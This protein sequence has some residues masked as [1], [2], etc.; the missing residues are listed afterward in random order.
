M[1]IKIPFT[2][3]GYFFIEKSS[4]VNGDGGDGGDGGVM[5]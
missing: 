2:H 1:A 4:A 5:G 3:V